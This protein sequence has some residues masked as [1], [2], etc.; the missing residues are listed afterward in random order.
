MAL[1]EIRNIMRR[2]GD[3]TAV[4]DVSLTIEAGGFF[5]LRARRGTEKIMLSGP[6]CSFWARA[7]IRPRIQL[8]NRAF[9]SRRLD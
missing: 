5:C 7:G 3:F 1:L 9:G 2:F 8:S 6:R 4:D